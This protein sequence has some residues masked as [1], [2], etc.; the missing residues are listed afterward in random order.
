M[1]GQCSVDHQHQQS[2]ILLV[3]PYLVEHSSSSATALISDT[4][5]VFAQGVTVCVTVTVCALV[6]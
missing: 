2:N 1:V 5:T 4:R 6:T 3:R